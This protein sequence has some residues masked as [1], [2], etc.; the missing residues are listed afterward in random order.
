MRNSLGDEAIF[1]KLAAIVLRTST[2]PSISELRRKVHVPL[3]EG[4]LGGAGRGVGNGDGEGEGSGDGEGGG[5]GLAP[6]SV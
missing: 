4:G 5:K 1:V 6:A 2:S 3:T